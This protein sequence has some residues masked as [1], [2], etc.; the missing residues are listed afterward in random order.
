MNASISSALPPLIVVMPGVP[1]R[2]LSNA[3]TASSRP[4]STTP[5]GSAGFVACIQIRHHDSVAR[6]P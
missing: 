1:A 4:A 3:A 2:R 5:D 6:Y